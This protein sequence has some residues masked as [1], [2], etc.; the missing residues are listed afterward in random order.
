[1]KV[2]KI[3]VVRVSRGAVTGT[4]EEFEDH[5]EKQ[6]TRRRP[7]STPPAKMEEIKNPSLSERMATLGIEEES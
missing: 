6:H 4:P 5:F 3:P 7:A 1:M 2:G